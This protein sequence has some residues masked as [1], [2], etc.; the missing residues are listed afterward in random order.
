MVVVAQLVRALDCDSRGWGFKSPHPPCCCAP[1]LAR[2]GRRLSILPTTI[3]DVMMGAPFN[4]RLQKLLTVLLLMLAAVGC[5]PTN[6]GPYHLFL[7]APLSDEMPFRYQ[8]EL[9]R[10]W[11]VD[12]LEVF[13]GSNMHF[14]MLEGVAALAPGDASYRT[15]RNWLSG[16]RDRGDLDIEVIRYDELKRELGHVHAI[17]EQGNR[18]N[19]ALEMLRQGYAWFDRSEGDY[20]D[21]YREAERVAREQKIGLW[22]K[23]SPV[24]PWD[25]WE[26]KQEKL[27][28]MV[29]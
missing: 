6:S 17:D 26:R 3:V 19:L 14:M 4:E 27:R 1:F 8:G 12:S 23:P 18:V 11:S 20:A 24:P 7:P 16:F 9:S 25:A 2:R 15:A 13:D 10:F 21:E 22:S 28:T 29:K 5:R